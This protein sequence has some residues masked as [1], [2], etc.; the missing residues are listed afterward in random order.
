MQSVQF[1]FFSL[2]GKNILLIFPVYCLHFVVSLY[3]QHI[4]KIWF[5][6]G[7][8]KKHLNKN[9]NARSLNGQ[10][11][12]TCC[13]LEPSILL[14]QFQLLK[15]NIYIAVLL[16]TSRRHIQTSHAQNTIQLNVKGNVNGCQC[17]Y[18]FQLLFKKC[19]GFANNPCDWT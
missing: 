19:C 13:W 12:G 15:W 14:I 16:L 6:Y 10:M 18:R 2:F 7:E 5:F 3:M 11:L 8:M 9:M 1:V 4:E 17:Q